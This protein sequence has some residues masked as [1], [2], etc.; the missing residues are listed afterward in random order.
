[1]NYTNKCY[2]YVIKIM[3]HIQQFFLFDFSSFKIF[4]KNIIHSALAYRYLV[5]STTHTKIAGERLTSVS[6]GNHRE[7]K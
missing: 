5:V 7:K 4:N 1:M 2:S 3:I 6:R